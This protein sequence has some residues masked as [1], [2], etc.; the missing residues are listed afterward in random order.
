MITGKLI[1]VSDKIDSI[2]TFESYS[3][4]CYIND[5]SLLVPYIK[6][7]LIDENVIENVEHRLN[8]EF[9][10]LIFVGLKEINWIGENELG[11]KIVGGKH[12]AKNEKRDLTDWLAINRSKEGYEIKV[13]F[14]R[15]LIFV[16][17]D[18]RT[19]KEWW[20]HRTTPNFPKNINKEIA[21][22]F[23]ELIKVPIELKEILKLETYSTLNFENGQD[24]EIELIESNWTELK[25][26]YDS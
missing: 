20:T 14:E 15:L 10:Y 13:I 5:N 23:F 26:C 22:G 25:K 3:E 21:K 9:S 4:E 7:E 11:K 18:S 1:D 2:D 19:G 8:I 6:L 12:F 17:I 16:P 24:K